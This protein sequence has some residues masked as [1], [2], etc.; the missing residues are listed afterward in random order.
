M[1]T[2]TEEQQM[3]IDSARRWGERACTSAERARVSAHPV[4][5]PPERWTELA[6]LGWLGVALPEADGGL[7]AGLPEISLLAEQLGRALAVEPYVPSVALASELLAE[8]ATGALR[9]DWLPALASGERRLAW[10]AWEPDGAATLGVPAASAQADGDG[11]RLNGDKGLMPG[12]GGADALLVT[13]R[14]AGDGDRL[15]LFLVQADAAGVELQST[16][17]YDGR[18]AARLRLT[19][20]PA[21]L[22]RDGAAADLLALLQ[23]ALDRAVV[24]HGA[25]TLGTA[26]GALDITLDYLRTRKQFGRVL[27][28]NQVLQHR[29]VDLYVEQQEARALCLAAAAD[30]S[31][32]LVAALG[33]RV[34]E[35]ARHA[36]EEGIQLHG[37]IGMTEEYALG[38][39]VRRLALAADLYG[40]A[41]DHQ[42]RL[43]QLALETHA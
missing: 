4:G 18:H 29:L 31:P 2:D 30:P 34:A 11:W 36:W 14:L 8:V 41:A 33:V 40:N 27:G 17:L 23:R 43:A 10:M 42:E 16:P 5:C 37:A 1:T 25:E 21:R 20:A 24:A 26:Q 13:A 38:E 39:Y 7:G 35:V 9:D 32:R 6:E 3:L 12:A 19:D 15:G 28:Q 22:L